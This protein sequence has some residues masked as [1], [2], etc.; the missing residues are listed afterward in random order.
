MPEDQLLRP[1]DIKALRN[2]IYESSFEA[3][4]NMEPVQNSRFRL[5]IENPR[6]ADP[7]NYSPA[8][9]KK[10]FYQGG[11][12]SRR[13]AAD[14]V[15]TDSQT[16]EPVSRR[17]ATVAS[18]P[19]MNDRGFFLLNGS[20]WYLGSQTRLD[21]GIYPRRQENGEISAYVNPKGGR[22]HHISLDPSN[23]VFYFEIGSNKLPLM[24]VLKA[25]GTDPDKIREAW[26]HDLVASNSEKDDPKAVSKLY[27]KLFDNG[28]PVMDSEER[29]LVTE[30]LKSWSFDPYVTKQTIG[31]DHAN[32]SSDSLLET[33][34]RLLA[35][36][37]KEAEPVDRDDQSFQ[38]VMGQEHLFAERLKNSKQILNQ[39]L[40]KATSKGNLDNLQGGALSQHLL[41][42][43]TGSGLGVNAQVTN[44]AEVL[45]AVYRVSKM[46]KGG[47][48]SLDSVP[49]STRDVS[50]TQ[51]GFID[52]AV[53]PESGKIGVDL[54]FGSGT[55]RSK[56]GRIYSKFHDAAGNPQWLSARDVRDKVIGAWEHKDKNE[57]FVEALKNGSFSLQPKS[58][59]ELWTH[60]TEHSFSPVANL[61]P[62]KSSSPQHRTA[63]GARMM[64]QAL[65]LIGGEA[66]LVQTGHPDGGSFEQHY[67][68]H[69]GAIRAEQGGKI[70]AVTPDNIKV[71][72]EDGTTNEI[73]LRNH[74]MYDHAPGRKTHFTQQAMLK[75]G[76]YFSKDQ[77]LAKSNYT[78]DKGHVALGKNARVAWLPARMGGAF[79][80]AFAVSQSYAD[81]MKSDHMAVHGV[82]EAGAEFGKNK[83]RALYANKY[84]PELLKDLDENGVIK[85]GT[86]VKPGQPLV[87]A[88]RKV[89]APRTTLVRSLKPIHQ[90]ISEVWDH[91]YPGQVVDVI[92]TKGGYK[93]SVKSEV[94]MQLGDK[95][96]GR[97]GNKGIV[98]IIPDHEMP[99]GED[100]KPFD[101]LASPYTLSSRKND[102]QI[103]EVVLGK[104]A[105]K[106]GQAYAVP[107]FQMDDL[108]KFVEDEARKYGVNPEATESITDPKTGTKIPGVLTGKQYFMKLHH[109]VESKIKQRDTGGYDAFD[110]PAK[111]GST[112]AKRMSLADTFALVAHGANAFLS[113]SQNVR[114]QRNENWWEATMSGFTP[115]MPGESTQYQRFINGLKSSGV[116]PV[117]ENGKIRLKALTD[118]HIQQLAGDRELL[119]PKGLDW[120]RDGDPHPGGLFD[121]KIFGEGYNLWG[122]IKLHEKLPNPAFED[123]VRYTLGL[124]E[125][126]MRKVIAGQ[127]GFADNK[128]V[129]P[130]EGK[131]KP[132]NFKTGSSAL[133]DQLKNVDLDKE[134]AN[135]HGIIAGTKKTKRDAAIRR[136]KYLQGAK[137][138]GVHPSQWMIENV[139]VLPPRFRPVSKLQGSNTELVSDPNYLY[140]DL[141]HANQNLKSLH[142]RL[143]DLSEE[144]LALYDSLKAVTGLG[145]PINPKTQQKNV[146]GMMRLLLAESPKWSIPQHKLLSSPVDLVGRS[147]IAPDASLDMDEI[148]IPE[149]MAFKTY[150]R[151]VIK[152]LVQGGMSPVEADR[153]V[154]NKSPEA[155]TALL[156]E[157]D[158]R[159]ISYHRAPV[160][161][162]FGHIGA[163]PKLIKGDVIKMSPFVY[164]GMGADNDG[165]TVNIHVPV[166][167][168]EIDDITGKMMP[169]KNLLSVKD[170]EPHYKPEREFHVGLWQATEAGD[171]D[172]NPSR[173]RTF[174]DMAALKAAFAKGEVTV[175]DHV[176]VLKH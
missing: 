69:F 147:T 1:M 70:M 153:M 156:K 103:A 144:K 26:G 24:S 44:P 96:A 142:G 97:H 35:I 106:R 55:A 105:E 85:P 165:D 91:D 29:R 48:A 84:A 111:G 93:V 137:D 110:T 65:P 25:M 140:Q 164:K 9:Q 169:S 72:Y 172:T 102:S 50:G 78:D 149:D 58:A 14:W 131:P 163:W 52:P 8:Q 154:E 57:P 71:K 36:S 4:K 132:D 47:I 151:F 83:F 89:D 5:S 90:D 152:N 82:D 23:G 125:K 112:G 148:G 176:T 95:I 54:R 99:V 108:M 53:T 107:D 92:K 59:I 34:K 12:L 135:A 145:D 170:F 81:S 143:E 109:V 129:E 45:D 40:W 74:E 28:K 120:S 166:Y 31:K 117:A 126:Q 162:Q 39:L 118:D 138:Q 66:P 104:I 114:G 88:F 123:P 139:P 41:E 98:T 86:T 21:P 73:S 171:K 155:R 116:H 76:E 136:L 101:I 87:L 32:Y 19:H 161:H 75:P 17:S 134:I 6:W 157:M 80:D 115:P 64:T 173:K 61:V 30:K 16:N 94:P 121:K 37:R 56:D 13:I 122:K 46:G 167:D 33:T 63:M 141:F 43:I 3:I 168:K 127:A 113:G 77:L 60:P 174:Q 128:F 150:S 42:T 51:F 38:R 100:G 67:G 159:P 49:D 27:K 2:A 79:E 10:A 15:L 146:K 130:E 68:K 62:F 124:T 7:E 20:H 160:L 175:R 119:N 158:K 22:P 11:T 133:Y 18:V